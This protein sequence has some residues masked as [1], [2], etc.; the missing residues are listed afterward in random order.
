L[1]ILIYLIN[2]NMFFTVKIGER[3]SFAKPIPLTDNTMNIPKLQIAEELKRLSAQEHIIMRQPRLDIIFSLNLPTLE[4]KQE[5]S[6][7]RIKSTVTR[8]MY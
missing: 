6:N 1:F 7:L 8:L 5:N 3:V 2:N 4:A